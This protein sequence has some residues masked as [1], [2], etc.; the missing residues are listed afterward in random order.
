MSLANQLLVF[1]VGGGIA[2]LAVIF[3]QYLWPNR[4]NYVNSLRTWF[5][6]QQ[7]VK[8]VIRQGVQ[9]PVTDQ[10]GNPV[11]ETTKKGKKEILKERAGKIIL[12]VILMIFGSLAVIILFNQIL[13]VLGSSIVI[14]GV[15]TFLASIGVRKIF[16]WGLIIGV[17]LG[18][19]NYFLP[20][21]I[22]GTITLAAWLIFLFGWLTFIVEELTENQ[23]NIFP[24]YILYL[25]LIGILVNVFQAALDG[26][27][28]HHVYVLEVLREQARSD[29][30]FVREITDIFPAA[31][32][33]FGEAS[34]IWLIINQLAEAIQWFF[35]GII[36]FLTT[37]PGE[38]KNWVDQAQIGDALKNF[39]Y[40]VLGFF[41][42][43]RR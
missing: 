32:H 24:W 28:G 20:E 2:T 26:T 11:M 43:R 40:S 21:T 15:V 19:I 42:V 38:I 35:A 27:M 29:S 7:K 34:R 36:I 16:G 39:L 12:H 13:G 8:T 41:S 3:Q 1:L 6:G 4:G 5:N 17:S 37:A 25:C 22:V 30:G 10:D 18:A 14:G 33:I 31:S 9:R 23:K